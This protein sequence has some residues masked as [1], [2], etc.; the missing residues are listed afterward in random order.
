M[1]ATISIETDDDFIITAPSGKRYPPEWEHTITAASE[2]ELRKSLVVFLAQ[3]RISPLKPFD[4]LEY[5]TER[6]TGH[7]TT[8]KRMVYEAMHKIAFGEEIL[9]CNGG[10]YTLDI[11]LK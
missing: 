10:N 4:Q 2:E 11:A 1:K 7:D 9:Y 5:S 6:T 8:F 3:L